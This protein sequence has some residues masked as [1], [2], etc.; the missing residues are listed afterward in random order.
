MNRELKFGS[1][2]YENVVVFSHKSSCVCFMMPGDGNESTVEEED[3]D[4]AEYYRQ[5]VGQEPD[6]GICTDKQLELDQKVCIYNLVQS[7]LRNAVVVTY[8]RKVVRKACEFH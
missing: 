7:P 2:H 4:D 1:Q 6:P 5:E 3:D 8:R